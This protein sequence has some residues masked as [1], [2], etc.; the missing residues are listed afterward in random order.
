MQV[1]AATTTYL[2]ARQSQA[3]ADR[4]WATQEWKK[5]V[6][7]LECGPQRAKLSETRYVTARTQALAI[8]AAKRNAMR[9][10]K[11]THV[12]CRYATAQDLGCVQVVRQEKPL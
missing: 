9:V 7:T 10:K 11:P 12:Q 2:P 6:V 5:Y 8:K 4:F 3:D 1:A